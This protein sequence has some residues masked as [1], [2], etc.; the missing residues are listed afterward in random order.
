[1]TKDEWI[2]R[3]AARYRERA[4][5]TIESSRELAEACFEAQ[6]RF[7]PGFEFSELIDYHPEDC[8]DEDMRTI[9]TLL[10]HADL[11]TTQIYTHVATVGAAGVASPLD[12]AQATV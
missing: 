3:C 2:T 6:N 5:L 8:A 4:G 12:L 1:M 7:E 10:G 9:Q 11:T